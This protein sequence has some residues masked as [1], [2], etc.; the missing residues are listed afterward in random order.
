MVAASDRCDVVVLAAR[1]A[2]AGTGNVMYLGVSAVVI[3]D[4]LGSMDRPFM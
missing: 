3:R 4:D 2:A 1:M